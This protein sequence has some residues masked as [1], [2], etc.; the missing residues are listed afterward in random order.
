MTWLLKLLLSVSR[1]L[2]WRAAGMGCLHQFLLG[3]ISAHLACFHFVIGWCLVLV[4]TWLSLPPL[5]SSCGITFEH[6]SSQSHNHS[7]TIPRG[8]AA[9]SLRSWCSP[10]DMT[11]SSHQLLFYASSYPDT[12][13]QCWFLE[14][15]VYLRSDDLILFDYWSYFLDSVN[16]DSLCC[17]RC[18]P[19]E[20][21]WA[22]DRSVD[23]LWGQHCWSWP[24]CGDKLLSDHILRN[25]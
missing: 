21:F 13:W 12:W 25:H 10:F 3:G 19:D 23:K 2:G 7:P 1:C 14:E 17:N 6:C 9:W 22:C 20:Q 15:S 24:H 5:E 18:P 16:F 4:E 11:T 8:H